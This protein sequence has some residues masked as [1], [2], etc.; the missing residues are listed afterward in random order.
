MKT[1]AGM[2]IGVAGAVIGLGMGAG[3]IALASDGGI[4]QAQSSRA[5]LASTAAATCNPWAVVGTSGNLVRTG[6][7]GATS[8][9]I[10]TGGYQVIFTKNVRNC[11]YE[12]TLGEPGHAKVVLPVGSI[13]VEGANGNP[14]GVYVQTGDSSD[15]ATDESFQLS[16]SC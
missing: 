14:D 15:V 4:A 9:S 5:A 1:R 8:V 3:G 6:C 12:A 10:F 16:V 11:A 2:M 13:A 7:P